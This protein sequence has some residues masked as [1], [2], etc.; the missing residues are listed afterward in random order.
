METKTEELP[1]LKLSLAPGS[2]VADL[3]Q[4][5]SKRCG[6]QALDKLERCALEPEDRGVGGGA[7]APAVWPAWGKTARM[8]LM[9]P[10]QAPS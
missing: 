1:D 2:T 10:G 8:G 5:V 6:W 3:Q 9:V 7:A 4:Q